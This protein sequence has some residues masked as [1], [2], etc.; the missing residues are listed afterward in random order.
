MVASVV[1]PFNEPTYTRGLTP[2]R[3][4]LAWLKLSVAPALVWARLVIVSSAPE[5][6]FVCAV[7]TI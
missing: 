4:R 1:T 2:I 3:P 7:G 5:T 6:P